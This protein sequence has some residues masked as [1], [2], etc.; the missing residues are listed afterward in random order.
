MFVKKEMTE[1]KWKTTNNRFVSFL[2]IMGFKDLVSRNSHEYVYKMMAKLSDARRHIEKTLTSSDIDKKYIDKDLYTTS[3]SDSIILFSADDTPES[4]EVILAATVF[5]ISEAM[6]N[7]IPIKGSIAHGEISVNKN[8]QIYFGQPIIDAYLL[9]EE[10]NYYGSVFHNSIDKYFAAKLKKPEE[11]VKALFFEVETPLKSG[12]SM[13]KNLNWFRFIYMQQKNDN[14]LGL[15]EFNRI[16]N[17][18]RTM[19]SGAPRKYIDNTI[20]VHNS[21]YQK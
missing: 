3:F 6:A 8:E 1:N 12:F 15:I 16:M 14:S 11:A 20:K 2:D 13:H 7:S 21:L 18:L 4:L 5:V 19:V 10:V 9:Q 17:Q